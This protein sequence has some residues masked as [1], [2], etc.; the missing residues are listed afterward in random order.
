[1]GPLVTWACGLLGYIYCS[2]YVVEIIGALVSVQMIWIVTGILVYMAVQ[3]VIH[4]EYEINS[5]IM[6][7]TAGCAVF[8]N[9]L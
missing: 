1:M 7:I 8:V 2:L 3:R 5:T 6:M 4:R 9:I